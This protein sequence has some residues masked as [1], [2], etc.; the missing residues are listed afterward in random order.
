[1]DRQLLR[2]NRQPRLGS[3]SRLSLIA[4]GFVVALT[5][6]LATT[7][8]RAGEVDNT[9]D[10]ALMTGQLQ[11]RGEGE[12]LFIWEHATQKLAIYIVNASRME[13]LFV[14]DCSFDFKANVA[15]GQM[16]PTVEEMDEIAKKARAGG[17]ASPSTPPDPNAKGARYTMT[18]GRMQGG[19]GDLLYIYGNN[20]KRLAVYMIRGKKLELAFLRDIE[21]D[22]VPRAM[23]QTEPTPAQMKE[24]VRGSSNKNEATPR[25][26]APRKQQT[27][28]TPETKKDGAT[29]DANGSKPG[30]DKT[31]GTRDRS[32]PGG[33]DSRVRTV[34]L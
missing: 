3:S 30:E 32:A 1:M 31:S 34:S 24:K 7:T 26:E 19:T 8:V 22:L 25:N 5:A 2:T 23:G 12:A 14:R 18:L 10:V 28:G 15:I 11:G 4:L 29:K 9:G 20:E 21:N 33:A 27:E 17:D 13:L 16:K 6:G